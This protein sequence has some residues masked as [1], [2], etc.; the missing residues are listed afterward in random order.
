MRT[1]ASLLFLAL[2]LLPLKAAASQAPAARNVLL[3]VAD[4]L[5]PDLGCYGNPDVRTPRLDALARQGVR[6][7]HAFATVA[8]CSPSRASL[9]TG[10][11]IHTNGQYGLAHAVHNQHTFRQAPSLPRVLRNAGYRTGIIGKLHVQPKEA[12]PFEVEVTDGLGGNRDVSAIAGRAKAFFGADARPFLLVVGFADPHRAGRGFGNNRRYPGVAETKYDPAAL[13]LAYFLPDQPEVRRDLA[14]YYE[15]VSRLDAGVGKVLDALEASGRADDTL[16]LFLSDNGMPF[17]GAKTTLYDAGVRLPLIVRRPGQTKPGLTN[18][19]MAS[20]VDVAPT[21]LDWAGVATPP[22]MAGRSLLPVLED[23]RPRGWDE[24]YG[25]HVFHEVT[26]Y[27]PMRMVRTRRH[28]YVLNLAHGLEFPFASDIHGSPTWQAVLRRDDR[29]MGRRTVE[30]FLRRPREELYD[31]EA[32]PDELRNVAADPAYA[33]A[34]NDLRARMKAWQE[35]TKDPWVV[36]YEH[37]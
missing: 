21:V 9:F 15:A 34:L 25:S 35:R 7:T 30:Q 13:K 6:F 20:W 4:D 11:F 12:Y 36:K 26:M 28:K 37:E 8:S 5:G 31:L 17:P 24:V 23:E 19:A 2:A 27:Y 3:L 1:R 22:A 10:Q 16:V 33:A 14:D 18:E 29:M 32:D